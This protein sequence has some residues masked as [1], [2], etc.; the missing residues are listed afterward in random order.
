M[1]RQATSGESEATASSSALSKWKVRPYERS[2]L[3]NYVKIKAVH[4]IKN[5]VEKDKNTIGKTDMQK[6][7]F[8]INLIFILVVIGG[9]IY[10]SLPST[11]TLFGRPLTIRQGLDLKGGV[12]LK[13]ELDYSRTTSADRTD[14]LNSTVQVIER[15]VNSTGVAEPTIQP[16]KIGNKD[17]VTV[18][19][20]GIEDVNQAIDLIGKTALLEF[21]EVNASGEDWVPTGLSGKQLDKASVSFDQTT[22]RPQVSLK[23]NADGQRLFAEITERNVQKPLAI[24]LDDELLQAPTV[25]Q[26]I[27]DGEAVITGDYSIQEVR[28]NVNLLNSGALDVPIKLVEQRTIGATLGEES[29]RKSIVAGLIGLMLVALFMLINYRFA[30]FVALLALAGYTAISVALFKFIPVTLTL[31]GIAGFILSIG[32]AVDANILIFERL[33]EELANGRDL[34]VALGE[35]FRRAWPSVRDSNMATLITCAILFF[36]TT[37][38]VKGFALTLAIGVLVSMF[39]SITASR[40]FLRLFARVPFFARRL[41]HV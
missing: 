33:R 8:W 38:S 19:L 24:F 1:D 18:E 34:R 5:R 30:G 37:G 29:V 31:A 4:L 20:P 40:S 14:A 12:Y 22:N 16:G 32:M 10:I 27:V 41:E 13:Y 6:R 9:A 17:V 35:A 3:F 36:T 2:L 15:R 39:S 26:K 23:F 25:Q 7:K 21:K 28:D 11:T